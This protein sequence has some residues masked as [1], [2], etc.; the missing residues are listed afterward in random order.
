[1][2]QLSLAATDFDGLDAA[3]I[4][5]LRDRIARRG[6]R[7]I[8]GGAVGCAGDKADPDVVLCDDG[9]AVLLEVRISAGVVAVEMGVDD[10]FDRQRRDRLDGGF[11]LVGQR[12]K[13]RIH[14]DD[15]V[16]ADRNRDIAALAL[17]HIGVVAKVGGLDLDL[18]P[19][20]RLLSHCSAGAQHSSG[21]KCGECG[22]VHV[23]SCGLSDLFPMKWSDLVTQISCYTRLTAPMT[24][25]GSGTI[26]DR[27][28]DNSR[29]SDSYALALCGDA[30]SMQLRYDRLNE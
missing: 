9:G 4:S 29:R 6:G 1:M 3:D 19:I 11:D 22:L 25:S 18:V 23:P 17:E 26:T 15:A 13:L 8:A 10:V 30:R 24:H 21:R 20:D 16:C 14:H 28:P 12:R 27:R 7:F 5:L 2:V